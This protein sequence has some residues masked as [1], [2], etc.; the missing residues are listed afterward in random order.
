LRQNQ[1]GQLRVLLSAD[2]EE[3]AEILNPQT[4]DLTVVDQNKFY[5]EI[6]LDFDDD[7]QRLE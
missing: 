4:L 7:F 2:E 3:S 5:K 6:T 1:L